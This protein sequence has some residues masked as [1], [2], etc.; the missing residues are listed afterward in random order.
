M[1]TVTTI[2]S[3]ISALAALCAVA[4]SFRNSLKIK[5][6]HVSINSRMDQ[7]L[8]ARGIAERAEGTAAGL[9]QG[10][11]EPRDTERR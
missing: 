1:E 8:A 3:L 7:L 5:E 6:V 11:N 10:R 4:I 9:E 2:T